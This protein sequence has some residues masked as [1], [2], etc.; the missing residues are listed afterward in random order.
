MFNFKNRKMTDNPIMLP[1]LDGNGNDNGLAIIWKRSILSLFYNHN[2][3]ELVINVKNLN[4][5]LASRLLLAEENKPE[6]EN[7]KLKP[8]RDG[9]PVTLGT[10]KYRNDVYTNGT[11]GN[12]QIIL[13]NEDDIRRFWIWADTDIDIE[14]L[15]TKRREVLEKK[16][17]MMAEAKR[18]H[19]QQMLEK[20]QAVKDKLTEAPVVL[21]GGDQDTTEPEP[22][23]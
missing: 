2:T 19:E 9:R 7:G 12:E 13:I 22:H 16:E 15:F 11:G 4:F 3:G 10:G 17:K 23:L 5:H 18:L 8:G 20:E 14:L 21:M 1:L 6:I